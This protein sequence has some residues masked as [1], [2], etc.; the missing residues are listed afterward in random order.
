MR[1]K[2]NT[3]LIN[4]LSAKANAYEVVDT[5]LKG[6]LIRVQPTGRKTA[7][8]A[9][10]NRAGKKQRIKVG[11][12]GP[13]FTIRQA[14]DLA[15]NNSASVI[16]GEDVHKLKK[17]NKDK[18]ASVEE[19]TL[20]YFLENHYEPWAAINRKS[21]AASLKKIE[22]HFAFLYPLQ[23]DEISILR[24][25]NWR[26]EKLQAG[27]KPTTIN[28][29][30]AALRAVLSKA[31]E[32]EFIELHPLTKLKLLRVDTSPNVRFLSQQEEARLQQAMVEYD[33]DL[34]EARQ[35]GNEFRLK[36]RYELLP[37]LMESTY[38]DRLVPMIHLSL[39]TGIRQG[40]L[41]ELCW[42]DVNVDGA[43]I[44]VRAETS[45]ANKTR[46]IPLGPTA[47][48]TLKAWR[49]QHKEVS[50]EGRVFPGKNGGRLN[51]VK[52]S[53]AQVLRRSSIDNFRWHDMRHDFASKLVM[54][55]VP[56]N[57]VRELCGHSDMNTT[58]RYAHLAPEHKAEAVASL[59]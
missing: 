54:N 34:K 17:D 58:L 36:R 30:T 37:S 18:A 40:E 29:V 22:C 23:L 32:W 5:V 21:G 7:Y 28:R 27:L 8:F 39:K 44:T 41:F 55:G 56:L 38:A 12:L 53:W 31:V 45:K 9:Y 13:S 52:K 59:G 47:L 48:A 46:H 57:T 26:T 4:S 35:R 50:G 42:R 6:F 1:A 14:R 10:R 11:T 51:N 33:R 43:V 3:T 16:Q 20:G 24:I 25:E 19:K 15:E 2:L 49:D